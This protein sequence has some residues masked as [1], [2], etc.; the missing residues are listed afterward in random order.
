MSGE[1]LDNYI[2]GAWVR[3]EHSGALPVDN[4]ATGEILAQVPLS[5]AAETGRAVAAAA[6]VYPGWSRMP[7]S[8]RVQHLFRLLELLR[9]DE[10]ELARSITLENG[11][12]LTDAR[13]DGTLPPERYLDR[14]LSWLRFNQRVLELAEDPT[15]PLLE[16][17]NF[18]AI[19]ATNLDEFFMVRVAGLK[20]RIVTGLAVPMRRLVGPEYDP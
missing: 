20:R 3:G 10:E 5:T 2:A 17:V 7:A 12:S 16:R 9:R 14:E 1:I 6:A 19:F 13:A 15:T 11:K 18:L 8:R 4:P